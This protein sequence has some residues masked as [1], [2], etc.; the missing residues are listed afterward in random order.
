MGIHFR[1]GFDLRQIDVLSI[2]QSH[3]LVEGEDQIE[4]VLRHVCLFQLAVLRNHSA[5]RV[6]VM[7]EGVSDDG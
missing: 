2:A 4:S 7:V 1:E 3:D 5:K 6:E